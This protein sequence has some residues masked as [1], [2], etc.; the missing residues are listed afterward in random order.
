MFRDTQMGIQVGPGSLGKA[1][2]RESWPRDSALMFARRLEPGP[3]SNEY[4]LAVVWVYPASCSHFQMFGPWEDPK[5]HF[6]V[7]SY[8][9]VRSFLE[10]VNL[11]AL[12]LLLFKII[13]VFLGTIDRKEGEGETTDRGH[14]K[15]QVL[16][17]ALLPTLA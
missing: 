17:W 6:A 12:D 14:T 8:G 5:P 4:K 9:Q 1:L 10:N 15:R 16:C 3:E 11:H 2:G 13:R 7:Q